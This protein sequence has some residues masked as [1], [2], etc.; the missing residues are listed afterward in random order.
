MNKKYTFKASLLFLMIFCSFSLFADNLE[1]LQ[2]PKQV[3][4][5]AKSFFQQETEIYSQTKDNL[6]SY[7]LKN[8]FQ[9]YVLEDFENPLVE[10]SFIAK[11]GF[12]VQNQDNSGF[13]ELAYRL[14][15]QND[16]IE[17]QLQNQQLT[18]ITSELKSD[19]V[20]FQGITTLS[21]LENALSIFSKAAQNQ[22]FSEKKILAEYKNLKEKALENQKNELAY[23]N[24]N[25][26]S[27]IF[28]SPW[29]QDTVLY[30]GI[31]QNYT[32]EEIRNKIFEIY[33]QFYTPEKSCIFVTGSVNAE[34]VLDYAKNYFENW[35]PSIS[36]I[37][38]ENQNIRDLQ[39]KKYVLIS[40]NFSTDYN[41]LI[42][43]YP[44]E[45][46]FSDIK[47]CGKL[48]LASL[49]LE[50]SKNF[51]E[52]VVNEISGIYDETYIYSGFAENGTSSRVIIQ[53]LMENGEVSPV[54]QAENVIS[55]IDFGNSILENE[56]L[57]EKEKL[58][59]QE[60]TS[61][62]SKKNLYA[63][64]TSTWAYGG[65]E[66]F[67][68][69]LKN[70]KTLSFEDTKS[71]FKTEPYV[72]LLVNSKTYK[73]FK[74]TFEENGYI[75]LTQDYDFPKNDEETYVLDISKIQKDSYY[76]QNIKSFSSYKLSNNIFVVEKSTNNQESFSIAISIKGGELFH[77]E[78]PGLE[79]ITIKYFAN[80]IKSF[81][82]L[83]KPWADFS[84][85]VETGIY[86]SNI[87]I[88][89]GKNDVEF[90]LSCIK[91]ALFFT[92]LT[93]AKADE[94]IFTENY[95]YRLTS[96]S[97]SFQ[98]FNSGMETIFSGTKLENLFVE[99]DNLLSGITFTEIFKSYTELLDAS[100]FSI[101]IIG[102]IPDLKNDLELTFG[103]L[104]SLN[105]T[106]SMEQIQPIV[107]NATRFVRLKRTFSTDIKAEDAGPR[108]EK[109][110]PT[111]VFSDPVDFYF[112][113][114]SKL[115]DDY[116]I[117]LGL[118]TEFQKILNKNWEKDVEI[119]VHEF[120]SEK[121]VIRVQF[122]EVE[123]KNLSKING[124]FYSSLEEFINFTKSLTD[125]N[126]EQIKNQ[127]VMKYY[128]FENINLG[129]SKKI[130]Q[131]LTQQNDFTNY[132][133][134]FDYMENA[135]ISDFVEC[136]NYFENMSVLEVR[137]N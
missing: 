18:N 15:L 13:P 8:G 73:N 94:L 98:L 41:Q 25:I 130:I 96:N 125:E 67:Y 83:E 1:I 105:L 91:K 79:T 93:A 44:T 6:R 51:K 135:E 92:D 39:E 17:N 120:Y 61:R 55:S 33:N 101:V 110:I 123:T 2:T 37:V 52:K 43:Q 10:I 63:A 22:S 9:V 100:R 136:V 45:G 121:N 132:L 104:K 111:T 56:F 108:P 70:V 58:L 116:S 62:I 137:G 38:V 12:S 78:T 47:T 117:F 106:K 118:L 34:T 134:T 88:T 27:V 7:Q 28:T 26:D 107:S 59:Y 97:L 119:S 3:I 5:A 21:N 124:I 64:L 86:N 82:Q 29:K 87:N 89:C 30:S 115:T 48:Q 77:A 57:Q 54:Y 112:E 74:S 114:P 35:K 11:A 4:S 68:N 95:N 60:I 103:S 16:N 122:K 46:L 80:N 133:K 71:V 84:I 65:P 31:I 109:L 24:S 128:N 36:N 127:F 85:S 131:G 14:F 23:I 50:N 40:D 90:L 99:S 69:Y 81:F 102:N 19:S 75:L 53:S 66:Y 49:A 42:L 126:L 76:Q 129:T 32:I 20:I 72:F 113:T